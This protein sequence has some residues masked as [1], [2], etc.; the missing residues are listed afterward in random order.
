M[1]CPKCHTEP[2]DKV[3]YGRE[4]TVYRCNNCYGLWFPADSYKKLREEWMGHFMDIGDPRIGKQYNQK[5]DILSPVTG[6]PMQV[7][8][9]QKQPHIQYEIDVDGHGAFFDAGEYRDYVEETLSDFFKSFFA[10]A[11]RKLTR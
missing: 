6:K 5:T 7:V 3:N 8:Y 1:K 11:A 4:Y 9:D 10:V 2:M